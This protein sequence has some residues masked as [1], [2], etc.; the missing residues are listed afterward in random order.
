MNLE[1]GRDKLG[2]GLLGLKK[3]KKGEKRK[4][5]FLFCF[6]CFYLGK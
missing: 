6:R 5:F 1:F 4:A 3:K 2:F